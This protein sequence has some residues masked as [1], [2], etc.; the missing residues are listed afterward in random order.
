MVTVLMVCQQNS[1]TVELVDHTKTV[2]ASCAHYTSVDCNPP[3]PQLRFVVDFLYNLFLQLCGSGQD[4]DWHSASAAKRKFYSLL[5][6]FVENL[7]FLC[8][9]AM[10]CGFAVGLLI[11]FHATDAKATLFTARCYASAVLAMALC[12]SVCLSVRHKSELY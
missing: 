8:R 6:G 2:E 1:S 7:R 9:N 3:T 10:V 12:P 5:C 11:W 4:F